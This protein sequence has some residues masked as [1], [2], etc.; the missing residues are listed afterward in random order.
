MSCGHL[1]LHV[2]SSGEQAQGYIYGLTIG[3]EVA[4]RRSATARLTSMLESWVFFE[5]WHS[6]QSLFRRIHAPRICGLLDP[7]FNLRMKLVPQNMKEICFIYHR[8]CH[9]KP[10][11]PSQPPTTQTW[12]EFGWYSDSVI[13]CQIRSYVPFTIDNS[14][15][16]VIWPRRSSCYWLAA[17]WPGLL[18]RNEGII[19]IFVRCNTRRVG[20]CFEEV[21]K[22]WVGISR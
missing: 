5:T 15:G 11:I 9:L 18:D 16:S 20:I 22:L 6:V 12:A 4:G 3:V 21:N 13:V 19:P 10:H 7:G 14:C 2:D 1:G 8:I 17:I